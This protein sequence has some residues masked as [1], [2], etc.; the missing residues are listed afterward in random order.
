MTAARLPL[1]RRLGYGVG[2]FGF[3]LFF[4]TA[5]LYLLLYYTDVLGLDPAVGGWIFAGAL[6]WD[7]VADPVMGYIASRTRTRWGR[8]RPYLLFASLPLGAS[9]VLMFLPTGLT[10]TG[11]ALFALATH[12][13]FRTVYTVVS[14]PYLSLSAVMTQDSRERGTLAGVRMLSATF[15]GLLVAFFTLKLVGWFG[16]GDQMRGFL[17]VSILYGAVAT[18]IFLLV[19]ASTQEVATAEDERLPSLREMW[20]M[21]RANSA[22]WLVSGSL[23]MGSTAST[24]FGKSIPY[25]FKYQL[26]REDLIGGALA[27]LTASAMLSIP[28][29]SMLMRRTS[30]RTVSLSGTAIGLAGYL[31][32]ATLSASGVAPLLAVMALLGV[33]GGAGY[34]TFWAMVPDTVELGEWRTG[35]RAEGVVFGLICFVQKAALGVAVGLLGQLL[36]VIGYI[37]NRPQAAETLGGLQR[38]MLVGPIICV[39]LGAAC[40]WFYPLDHRTHSRLVNALG[41]RARRQGAIT[42]VKVVNLS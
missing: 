22:F 12:V 38:I 35:V 10:G 33:A 24:L 15:C 32:F 6:I 39:S 40:I 20:A 30:K 21:L 3:N 36:S 7:A 5:N 17:L 2:D 31:L 26:G 11:L 1:G 19:F 18:L 42:P 34:L 13:L 8:Y 14:M 4:T 9:W 27:I 28:F 16:A 37:A 23:L 29:W 41:W 25:F